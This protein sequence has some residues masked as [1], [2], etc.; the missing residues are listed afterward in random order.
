MTET[1][2]CPLWD[3]S[4]RRF[5]SR[6]YHTWSRPCSACGRKVVVNDALKRKIDADRQISVLCEQCV[7]V[8]SQAPTLRA[9]NEPQEP[10]LKGRASDHCEICDALRREEEIAAVE[11]AR[12]DGLPD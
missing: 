10:T 1:I 8:Q 11:K 7:L 9:L 12:C 2:T 6:R 5:R 4:D 3:E